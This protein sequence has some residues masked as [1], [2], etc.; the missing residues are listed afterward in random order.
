[1]TEFDK[2]SSL[3]AGRPSVIQ[4]D[5]KLYVS[6]DMENIDM[7]THEEAKDWQCEVSEFEII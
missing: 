5:G 7:E 3:H 4:H 2:N 1:M 6:Y